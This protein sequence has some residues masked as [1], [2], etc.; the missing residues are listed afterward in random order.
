MFVNLIKTQSRL[1][2]SA[3]AARAYSSA[4]IVKV[5]E[6]KV[7]VGTCSINYVQAA[8]ENSNP[9]RSLICLPGALG[10]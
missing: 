7:T 5:N 4:S 1:V 6:Q 3:L 2:A 10:E 8:L 9:S